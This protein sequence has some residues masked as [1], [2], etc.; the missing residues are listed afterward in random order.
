M[1]PVV[2]LASP[3]DQGTDSGKDKAREAL[4]DRGCAVF[5]PSAGW[6][7]PKWGE[8]SRGLQNGNIALLRKCDG[9]LAILNPRILTIGVVLEIQDA[10]LSGLAVSVYAP[11]VKPSWSLAYLDLYPHNDLDF[12]IDML[13]EDIERNQYGDRL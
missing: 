7:V 3:I 1:T 8:P 6:T 13:I 11:E 10:L 9:V 4:L 12:A 5:D 2:Y